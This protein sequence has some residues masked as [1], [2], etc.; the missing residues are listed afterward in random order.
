[1]KEQYQGSVWHLKLGKVR[2]IHALAEFITEL[3]TELVKNPAVAFVRCLKGFFRR[4]RETCFV[5]RGH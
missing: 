3:S 1:M 4:E 5:H 2:I